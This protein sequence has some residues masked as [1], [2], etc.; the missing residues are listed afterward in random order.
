MWFVG[1]KSPEPDTPLEVTPRTFLV[2]APNANPWTF[3]GTN[4]CVVI[5]GRGAAVID[6]GPGD[7]A[8]LDAIDELVRGEG[9]RVTDVLLTHHH[10]DHAE[11]A[12]E[13]A[14]RW[15]APISPRVQMGHIAEG[16]VFELGAGVQLRTH[17]TPGH[18]SDGVSFA[19]DEDRLMITGDTVLARVNPFINHPDG[20]VAD[21]LRSMRRLA[22]VVDDDWT[23]LPGHGPMVD[24]P[25]AHI[26]NRIEDRRRRIAEVAGHLSRGVERQDVARTVYSSMTGPRM[27]AAQASVNAILHYLDTHEMT[28][29][30]ETTP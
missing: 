5:G 14:A 12:T 30:K 20:T 22:E 1:Q 28:E 18:T 3:E 6:P 15:K 10:G 29:H 13:L 11:G 19:I 17:R 2:L 24:E 26:T 16:T 21:I 27:L 7:T 9:S 25:R 8:H 4:T 23:L